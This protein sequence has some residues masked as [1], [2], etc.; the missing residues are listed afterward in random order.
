MS[1]SQTKRFKI[2]KKTEAKIIV[3]DWHGQGNVT[4]DND[5]R[6]GILDYLNITYDV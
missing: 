3:F 4:T 1:Y 2:Q 6:N 5:F